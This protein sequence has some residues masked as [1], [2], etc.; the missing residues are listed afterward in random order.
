VV[1]DH[2]GRDLDAAKQW[3]EDWQSWIEERAA[4]ARLRREV[5]RTVESAEFWL[6]SPVSSR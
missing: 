6:D 1:S 3:V 5:I 2:L 4:R